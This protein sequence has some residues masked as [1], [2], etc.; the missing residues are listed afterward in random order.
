[1]RK[2]LTSLVA[3]IALLAWAA[4]AFA[5]APTVVSASTPA[6]PIV[7]I[8]ISATS[9]VNNQTT[10]TIPTPPGGLSNYVCY[11]AFEAS[12]DATS[13]A[14]SV[15]VTTSTNF[16]SFAAKFSQPATVNV[17]SGAYVLLNSSG[18]TGGCAK[19][20]IPGTATTFVSPT[21]NAHATWTWYATYFQAP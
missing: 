4:S 18:A 16:N 1:M 11:L 21:A 20:T 15:A 3:T 19:S 8:P 5:Q 17:D 13:T 14:F 12:Q 10:L 6:A 7:L 2:S 9:A